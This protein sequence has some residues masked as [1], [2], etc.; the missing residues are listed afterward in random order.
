MSAGNGHG[1][2][3]GRR[4]N[5]GQWKK[6]QSGNPKG[7]SK[8]ALTFRK[9]CSDATDELVFD[10]WIQEVKTLGPEWLRCS[11]LLAAYGKGMP[12]QRIEVAPEEMSDVELL[13]ES[14]EIVREHEW[15]LETTPE[16]TGA[17]H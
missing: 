10:A 1:G 6:G 11:K 13:R 9:K 5:A 12:T 3:P 8:V 15:R 17:E 2:G 16:E 4:T 7:T 14:R